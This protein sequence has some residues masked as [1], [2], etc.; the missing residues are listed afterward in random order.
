MMKKWCVLILLCLSPLVFGQVHDWRDCHFTWFPK[1]LPIAGPSTS[2]LLWVIRVNWVEGHGSPGQSVRC[3]YQG[4][5]D[6]DEDC[7]VDMYDRALYERWLSFT[8]LR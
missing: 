2:Q 7:D 6:M 8:L 3:G 4:R 5:F 1:N